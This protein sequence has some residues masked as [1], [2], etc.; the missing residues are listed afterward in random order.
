MSVVEVKHEVAEYWLPVRPVA[1][2][3]L[4]QEQR[5]LTRIQIQDGEPFLL[6]RRPAPRACQPSISPLD[7]DDRLPIGRRGWR[8]IEETGGAKHG[9]VG[10]EVWPRIAEL[11]ESRTICVHRENIESI[12]LSVDVIQEEYDFFPVRGPL[13]LA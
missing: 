6:G 3:R 11:R 5:F 4:G 10:A 13:R 12:N 1:Q 9:I 8:L 2:K 7:G